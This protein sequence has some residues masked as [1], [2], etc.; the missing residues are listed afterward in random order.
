MSNHSHE[1]QGG[2]I[3]AFAIPKDS[4]AP[5]PR[6]FAK[7]QMETKLL[8]LAEMDAWV[9]PPFQREETQSKKVIEFAEELKSNGG[10]I[11]GSILLGI[12]QGQEPVIVYLV[13]GQQRRC[14][15]HLSGLDEFIGDVSL[16]IYTSMVEMADDFK[17]VNS[18]LVPMKPDDLLRAYEVSHPNLKKLRE[19]CQFVGYGNIRRNEETAPIL[20]MSVA[21]K[22][23]FGSGQAT[24]GQQQQAVTLVDQLDDNQRQI[25]TVFLITAHT[26]WGHDRQYWRLWANLNLIMCM[27]LYRKLVLEPGSRR[28]PLSME[29]FRKCLMSASADSTYIDWLQGRSVT[30]RDRSPCYKRL[31][32]IFAGRLTQEFNGRLIKLPA[33]EWVA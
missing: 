33:P 8:S 29:M 30:E 23:W 19:D 27:Y 11:S 24:P 4:A 22:C 17:R 5:T 31:K 28:V 16:K 20:S 2:K 13:D 10:I 14:A 3:M 9:L 15:C 7:T 25:L 26:A 18:R 1:Q 21:L 12:L 6:S 32:T